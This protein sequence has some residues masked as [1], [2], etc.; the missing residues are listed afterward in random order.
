M[1]G[2]YHATFMFLA[3]GLQIFRTGLNGK[4]GGGNNDVCG[5]RTSGDFLTFKAVADCLAVRQ[6][7]GKYYC[8]MTPSTISMNETKQRNRYLHSGPASESVFH[9]G[10]EA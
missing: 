10:T 8:R 4:G 9:L 1:N 3:E 7:K 6:S 2:K 5:K